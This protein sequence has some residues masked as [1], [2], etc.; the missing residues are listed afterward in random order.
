MIW[1]GIVWYDMIWYGMI[2][3][4]VSYNILD[5]SFYI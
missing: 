4:T 5:T 1:Y 3:P 2:C